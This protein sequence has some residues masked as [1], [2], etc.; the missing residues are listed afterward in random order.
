MDIPSGSWEIPS[1]MRISSVNGDFG[2]A[3]F[4]Y[5]RQILHPHG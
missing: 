4:D 2:I 5:Q 1:K 3:M